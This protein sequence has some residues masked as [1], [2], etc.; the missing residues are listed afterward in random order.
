MSIMGDGA[1]VVEVR[2]DVGGTTE[3]AD[4]GTGRDVTVTGIL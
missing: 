2:G 1:W 4:K 3:R